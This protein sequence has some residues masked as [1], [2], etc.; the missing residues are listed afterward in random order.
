MDVFLSHNS[1]DKPAVRELKVLL[2]ANGLAAWLDEDELQPGVPWQQLLETGI[3]TSRSVA[4]LVGKDGLG[5]WE[6]EEMQA[7]LVLAVRD[8]RP[9]IPVLLPGAS[10]Q[11]ELPMFLG[12]RTWLNLRDGFTE[13]GLAKLIWGITGKKPERIEIT[14]Q[15]A[16]SDSSEVIVSPTRLHHGA[17]KLFGRGEELV[18]LDEAWANPSKHVVTI[19][20]FGGVGKTSLI[21]EW[22][23]RQAAKNWEGFE[24]VFDWSFYSQGTREEGAASA[25]SFTAE[26]LKFFGDDAMA[27]SAASAWDKGA[28]LA[29]LVAQ[30]RTLLV[31]DGVEPLQYPPG[32]LAGKLKDPALEQLL[33]GLAQRNPGLCFVTTRER[34][35][36]LA[37]FHETTAPE[38]ELEFLS[39]EAGAALL[40]QAGATRAG[41]VVIERDDRELRAASREVQGHALTLRLLGGYLALAEGGDI[42]KRAQVELEVADREFITN[43]A[44]ADMPYGH[45]FKVMRAYEEWL[46]SGGANG[47]RQLA[48]LRLLGLFDRPADSGCLA[49]LRKGPA[50]GGLSE[51]LIN[52]SEAEWNVTT[53]RLAD[54]GL[55]SLSGYQV[56]IPTS[57]LATGLDA[58]PLLREYFAKQLREH[59]LPAWRAAHR[60]VYEHLCA[61]TKEGDQPTLED[62]Q[63]LYQ[64]VAHGCQ[65]GLQQEARA[66]VYRDRIKR[67]QE[68]YSSKKLGAF[69]SDL[70]AVA[71]FFETP[72]SRVSPAL[73]EGDQAW[74]LNE[75]AFRLR[76]LGRPTEALD[77]FR[78]G[79][80]IRIKQE[81]WGNAAR[82]ASNLSELELTL[83]EVA[84]AVGDAE[85]SVTY[86]DRSGESSER[87]TK[88]VTVAHALHGAGRRAEAEARFR[89][90]ESLQAE[91]QPNYPLL[92]SL[93]GFEYCDLLLAP[94]ERAAWQL[95][96]HSSVIP[97][98]GSLPESCR[99]IS[100]RAAQTLDWAVNHF[101]FSLLTIALDH[102]T[103]A[104][105]ALYEA[106]LEKSEIRNL[107]FEIDQAVDG[108]RR[109]G[110]QDELPKALLTRAWL[111]F[112][113]GQHTGPASAQTDLDEAWEIAERGPMQLHMADIHLYRARLF[114]HVKPY[115]WKSPQEDL[116]AARKLIKQCG[117]WRRKEELEDAEVAAK[118]W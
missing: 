99:A 89:E 80:A 92:Y 67:G 6:D 4:V 37:P 116:A 39:D 91:S 46:K 5:P 73:R 15:R 11:P 50:I 25:D 65:A 118:N 48:V 42:R 20:A 28:R 29:R 76:A 83:G 61:T 53:T 26:A 111:R 12:N 21:F 45:A 55:V 62:L 57:K 8:K 30:H 16:K 31:L 36:D 27:E 117:Y 79:L 81:A 66:Q 41:A 23:A 17:D 93:Q 102:L 82:C 18:A 52:L 114:H 115:P 64:A 113:T 87:V 3:K 96:L 7:A 106:I 54:C 10:A 59:N 24:R 110:Q 105:A 47:L 85:Q 58:H 74:L 101:N 84:R 97:H 35:A 108:L 68:N 49:A 63:P 104:R 56:E 2:S 94:P 98:S 32:P 100:Q 34:V 78:A 1:K 38:W 88:R 103:L 109:A 43:P 72:W 51:P 40:H 75:A 60:R 95:I 13:E 107:K 44:D 112:L 14:S 69:G 77:P 22:M 70:G 9:V 71:C 90:A 86:A 19:V 33:R